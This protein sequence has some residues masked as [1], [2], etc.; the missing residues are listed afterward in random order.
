MQTLRSVVDERDHVELQR[1]HE[2]EETITQVKSQS[3]EWRKCLLPI[4]LT[5][6]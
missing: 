1:F 4:H 6:T 2:A 3:I 5:E